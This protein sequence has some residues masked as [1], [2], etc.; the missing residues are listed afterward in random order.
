FTAS[1][2]AFSELNNKVQE[3]VSGIKVTKSLGYQEQE[4]AAFQEV[5]QAAFLQNIKTRRY[6]ALFNPAVL[7]WIGLS[8]LLTLLV[9]SHFISQAQ[10]SL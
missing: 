1:H 8:Y 4:T 2:A 6:D 3:A 5:N 7:F 9:G 10:V